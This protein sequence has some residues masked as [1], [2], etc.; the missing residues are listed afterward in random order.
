MV[1]GGASGALFALYGYAEVLAL[2]AWVYGGAMP[3]HPI[4]LTTVVTPAAE[5]LGKA[6][7]L[8]PF[9]LSARWFRGPVDGLLYGFAAGA[10]FACAEN[11]LYFTHAFAAGG[12][13]GWVAEVMGRA[14]PS[15]VIHGGATAAVGAFLGAARFDG[16]HSVVL[17]AP[18]SGIALAM[19]IHGGWNLFNELSAL[20]GHTLYTTAAWLMLPAV[21]V[22]YVLALSI[23]LDHESQELRLALESEYDDGLLLTGEWDAATILARRHSGSWSVP[24]MNRGR[25]LGKTMSLGYA[26]RRF[27]REGRG[28]RHVNRLRADVARMKKKAAGVVSIEE[29]IDA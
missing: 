9:V 10:G 26:L 25:M 7:V 13:A 2:V 21:F 29:D 22:A 3:A 28:R 8:L 12:G 15:A 6:F 20:T 5:E 27:R 18:V 19:L 11:F 16:R 4:F 23:A 17:V 1:A 24:E 14:A